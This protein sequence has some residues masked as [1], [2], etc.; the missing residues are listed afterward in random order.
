MTINLPNIIIDT[1]AIGIYY[2]TPTEPFFAIEIPA[3][4]YAYNEVITAD[5]LQ[6]L[7]DTI[8]SRREWDNGEATW[9]IVLP[10]DEIAIVPGLDFP[11]EEWFPA[12]AKTCQLLA[13]VNHYTVD[14]YN[15]ALRRIPL[16]LNR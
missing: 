4:E 3:G 5:T 2:T 9:L 8:Q 7:W 14:E 11:V 1:R 16:M 10:T 13:E 6:T 12:W 15:I